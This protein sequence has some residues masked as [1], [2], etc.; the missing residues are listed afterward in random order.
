MEFYELIP[1]VLCILFFI[2]GLTVGILNFMQS[3][4]NY[5]VK[6]ETKCYDRFSNEIIG[7]TCKEDYSCPGWI[8]KNHP[9]WTT[10]EVI[11]KCK[12]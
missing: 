9:S 3:L 1:L 10:D 4:D 8:I 7:V 12:I 5:T 11:R 2:S 6:I